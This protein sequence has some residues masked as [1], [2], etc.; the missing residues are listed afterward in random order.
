M[1]TPIIHTITTTETTPILDEL[2]NDFIIRQAAHGHIWI[3]RSVFVTPYGYVA[4]VLQ[5]DHLSE[6]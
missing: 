3:V 1:R 2:L 6:E 4:A 5:I